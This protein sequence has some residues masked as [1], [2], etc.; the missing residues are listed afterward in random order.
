MKNDIHV[1]DATNINELSIRIYPSNRNYLIHRTQLRKFKCFLKLLPALYFLH[2][3]ITNS[4]LITINHL[5][6]PIDKLQIF[7]EQ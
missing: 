1:S 5:E 7:S 6:I 2:N 4:N 3:E